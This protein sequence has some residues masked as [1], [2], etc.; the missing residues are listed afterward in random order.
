[1]S[2][3]AAPRWPSRLVD[4]ARVERAH[5]EI[6]QVRAGACP[7]TRP[8]PPARSRRQ[9][10]AKVQAARR[11]APARDHETTERR[12]A[13]PGSARCSSRRGQGIT[14]DGQHPAA[15]GCAAHRR[16]AR[17]RQEGR[18][19]RRRRSTARDHDQDVGT[20]RWNGSRARPSASTMLSAAKSFEAQLPDRDLPPED[21]G[22]RSAPGRNPSGP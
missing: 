21:A 6:R 3:P 13:R 4:E 22:G 7:A 9:P 11:P 5:E 16:P 8:T 12:S 20:T 15:R 2:T 10:P 19:A 18:A 17:W 1:M 14:Q